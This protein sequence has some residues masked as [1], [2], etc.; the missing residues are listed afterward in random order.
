MYVLRG[1]KAFRSTS[2]PIEYGRS[3][4]R[5]LSQTLILSRRAELSLSVLTME[6]EKLLCQLSWS[7]GTSSE[8]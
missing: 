7:T 6:A 3:E 8:E 2:V 1:R 5:G 4:D